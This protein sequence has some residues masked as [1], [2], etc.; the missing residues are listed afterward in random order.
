MVDVLESGVLL[1]EATSLKAD[2]FLKEEAS[3]DS[4]QMYLKEIG[5]HSLISGAM[6]K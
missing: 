3:Y 4:I 1:D 5:Q 6:E 2:H